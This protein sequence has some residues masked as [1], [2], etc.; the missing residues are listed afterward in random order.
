MKFGVCCGP[1]SFAPEVKN[2]PPR[3]VTQLLDMLTAARADFA[4]FCVGAVTPD[5]PESAFEKLFND[6]SKYKLRVEAFNS[7]IPAKYPITGPHADLKAA[8]GYC[9]R[10]LPRCRALGGEVV[11]LGSGAARRFPE[12]FP[13]ERAEAQFIEFCKELGPIAESNKLTIALEPLNSSDD[14]LCVRVDHGAR[15]VDAIGHPHIQLLADQFHIAY[16]KEPYENIFHA[17]ARL[18]HV[19]VADVGRV[20]PGFAPIGEEN[21]IGLFKILKQIKFPGRCSFEGKF[22]NIDAQTAPMIAFLRKRWEEA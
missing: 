21:F 9:S 18:R 1:G 12:D 19:H 3:P 4:E 13:R 5:E 11:V 15:L 22:D 14:N 16:E 8:L 7:F 6:V 20:A 10:A 17:G 2:Q